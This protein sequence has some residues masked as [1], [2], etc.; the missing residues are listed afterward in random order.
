MRIAGGHGAPAG[1][2]G[3]IGGFHRN[4]AL[5]SV[6]GAYFRR[7]HDRSRAESCAVIRSANRGRKRRRLSSRRHNFAALQ[8]RQNAV[9]TFFYTHDIASHHSYVYSGSCLLHVSS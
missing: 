8:V 4:L 6:D 5:S 2:V 9:L 7:R 1:I 3:R